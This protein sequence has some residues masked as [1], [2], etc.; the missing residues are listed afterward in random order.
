MR[1]AIREF[2]WPPWVDPAALNN[3]YFLA[4]KAIVNV[5]AR[6]Q[7]HIGEQDPI[8][9]IFDNESEKAIVLNAWETMKESFSPD[10]RRNIGDTPIFRDDK[11]TL[12]LQA[13]DLYAY[14]VR[15]W[16]VRGSGIETLDFPWKTAWNMKRMNHRF[17]GDDFN[18]EFE[19]M[20]NAYVRKQLV[21]GNVPEGDHSTSILDRG[22]VVDDGFNGL[23]K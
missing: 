12:P 1:K 8:S 23:P 20:L 18:R 21:M 7:H 17:A 15:E 9:F 16:E 4:F 10:I 19:H 6:E 3:P 13:A 5:L 2:D 22:F 14:W 11:S